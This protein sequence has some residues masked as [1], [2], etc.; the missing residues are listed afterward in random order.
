LRIEPIQREEKKAFCQGAHF[1]EWFPLAKKVL[2]L[3]PL[4]CE[5]PRRRTQRFRR[6]YGKKRVSF[7]TTQS[8]LAIPPRF[9]RRV[10]QFAKFRQRKLTICSNPTAS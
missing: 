1:Q 4:N 2:Q 10:A 8:K 9:R 3:D 7:R 5:T 6:S